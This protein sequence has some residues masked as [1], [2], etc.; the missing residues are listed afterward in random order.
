MEKQAS[1][2]LKTNSF[3]LFNDGDIYINVKRIFF[4]Y[5]QII[6]N[7]KS[8]VNVDNNK[9]RKYLE[10]NFSNEIIHKQYRQEYSREKRKMMYSDLMLFMKDGTLLNLCYEWLGAAFTTE[11]EQAAQK[12]IDIAISFYISNN[13]TNEI[14]LMVPSSEG[15][16][17]KA[18]KIKKPKLEL[19]TNY[20]DDVIEMHKAVV[21]KLRTKNAS[22]L[23]LFYGPPG[24]GKSTYIKFLIHHLNKNVI[25]MSPRIACNL[26][27]PE[28]MNFLLY[29]KNSVIVIEDAEEL[30]ATRDADRNSTISTLLN[31]TD[32]LLGECLH[33][34]IIAT[35]N[36]QLKN[37]DNALLRKGRLQGMYEFKDLTVTKAQ[38]LSDS[39]GYK[40]KITQPMSLANIYNQNEQ[41]YDFNKR[42]AIGFRTNS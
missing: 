33:I 20:N 41:Q 23:F 10:T 40:N 26:D 6:P 8:I 37:I 25:F 21:K 19:K 34:Q 36:T 3:G 2:Q 42:V 28:L 29:H 38:E 4:A 18:V 9:F 22:G 16:K 39:L 17:T 1:I 35:F 32:G 31:L 27:A 5:H 7:V 15:I 12:W 11:N 24:T 14:C 13:K 30:I